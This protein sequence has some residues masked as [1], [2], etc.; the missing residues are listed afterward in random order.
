M[1]FRHYITAECR[2]QCAVCKFGSNDSHNSIPVVLVVLCS[3]DVMIDGAVAKDA[4]NSRYE[5]LGPLVG[6]KGSQGVEKLE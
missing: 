2:L 5:H 1:R 3:K 4:D 6:T